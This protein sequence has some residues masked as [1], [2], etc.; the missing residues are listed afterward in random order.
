MI[1][2][3]AYRHIRYRSVICFLSLY[4][5]LLFVLNS[6]NDPCANSRT[7]SVK[8]SESNLRPCW[9]NIRRLV[10]VLAGLIV[11]LNYKFASNSKIFPFFDLS[12]RQFDFNSSQSTE[13]IV[14]PG[15]QW[16]SLKINKFQN[17]SMPKSLHIYVND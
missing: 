10:A 3:A 6:R 14:H 5:Y 7:I 2:L 13:K 9:T 17:W 15:C 8:K 11:S 12:R 4:K 16:I 1:L